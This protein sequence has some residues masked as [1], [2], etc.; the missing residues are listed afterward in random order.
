MERSESLGPNGPITTLLL[1]DNHCVAI[2]DICYLNPQ[3]TSSRAELVDVRVGCVVGRVESL[4]PNDPNT[5]LLLS[6]NH[7]TAIPNICYL[8]PQS[9]SSRAELP[10]VR[11]G[12]AVQRV[13]SLGPQGPVRVVHGGGSTDTFD[14]VVLATHSDITLRL[15]GGEQ[16]P[17]VRPAGGFRL[18]GPGT[19]ITYVT[20]EPFPIPLQ[21]S[22]DFDQCVFNVF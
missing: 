17:Q 18:S 8:N 2:P 5:T 3:S 16:A 7:R 4:G 11:V 9:T 6:Y 12:C 1:S 22:S 20:L 10:D 19:P 21:N 14:V 15:L 13:E